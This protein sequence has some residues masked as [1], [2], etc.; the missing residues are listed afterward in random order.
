MNLAELKKAVL[1]FL[2]LRKATWDIE[3]YRGPTPFT[4]RN[5]DKTLNPVLTAESVTD[6]TAEF[7]ADPF[8]VRQG[9]GWLMFFETLVRDTNKG[10]IC[11]ATSADGLSWAYQKVILEEPFHLSYPQG[12]KLPSSS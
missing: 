3:I 2:Q 10:V 4:L 5:A 11:L 6:V 12:I 1:P 9:T 7:I 8:L